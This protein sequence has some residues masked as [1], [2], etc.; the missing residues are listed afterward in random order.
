M[1]SE[2]AK[3]K[4]DLIQRQNIEDHAAYQRHET[5]SSKAKQYLIL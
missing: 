4:E 1:A 2:L 3:A 5:N